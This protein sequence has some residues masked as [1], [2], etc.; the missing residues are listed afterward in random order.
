MY[1]KQGVSMVSNYPSIHDIQVSGYQKKVVS[2][3]PFIQSKKKRTKICTCCR[4]SEAKF[5]LNH[6]TKIA[7]AGKGSDDRPEHPSV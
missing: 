5:Y 1:P 3:H 2:T 6:N 4:V 7:K